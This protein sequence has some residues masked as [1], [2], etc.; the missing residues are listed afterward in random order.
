MYQR[1]VCELTLPGGRKKT[2][3]APPGAVIADVETG[4]LARDPGAFVSFSFFP[5]HINVPVVGLEA[6]TEE[7]ENSEL[8]SLYG[9]VADRVTVNETAI[10]DN[11]AVD[12]A[13][14]NDLVTLDSRVDVLEANV[15][16]NS[17]SIG[18][19]YSVLTQL[20]AVGAGGGSAVVGD[21]VRLLNTLDDCGDFALSLDNV[22]SFFTLGAGVYDI[23]GAFASYKVGITY[24]EVRK[25]SD[26]SVLLTGLPVNARDATYVFQL[27]PISGKITLTETTE[28]KV[29]QYCTEEEVDTGLGVGVPGKVVS[30]GS[31]AV[32]KIHAPSN[33]GSL[34]DQTVS[35][36][37]CSTTRATVS[38]MND[39]TFDSED[40]VNIGGSLSL[41]KD[42]TLQPGSYEVELENSIL[43]PGWTY[44]ELL[45]D[46]VAL[47]T[48]VVVYAAAN[49][50]ASGRTSLRAKFTL[51]SAAVLSA[52]ASV[53][54]ALVD[55]F[56]NGS[57]TIVG[58]KAFTRMRIRKWNW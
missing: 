37:T 27:A 43:R 41:N 26:D 46:G 58:G 50:Y 56:H 29:V 51:A 22:T 11:D 45:L 13:Q 31:L 32:R 3:Y 44:T 19:D 55:G 7:P 21:N 14:A 57:P 20:S 35:V 30:H 9:T 12:V 24:V 47:E 25:V 15:T 48:S 2:I 4:A 16:G 36:L 54:S 33:I 18:S 23:V 10:A 39:I 53:E 6:A 8:L 49:Q 5:R 34:F 52:V 42:I 17:Y 28:L 38:G 40:L 1:R